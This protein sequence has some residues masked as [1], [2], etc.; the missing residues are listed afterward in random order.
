VIECLVL[1]ILFVK[2]GNVRNQKPLL[3]VDVIVCGMGAAGLSAAIAAHDAGA[4]VLIV[5]KTETGGGNSL[6]S[7]AMM[8]YPTDDSMANQLVA[9]LHEVNHGMTDES[10]VRTFV[11]ELLKNPAWFASL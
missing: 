1:E 10:L 8:I 3:E 5:E 9:Y 2:K 7:S 4:E 11:F 6:V